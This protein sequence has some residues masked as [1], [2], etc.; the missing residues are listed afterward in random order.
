MSP[1]YVAVPT[2]TGVDDK[3]ASPGASELHARSEPGVAPSYDDDVIHGGWLILK[4]G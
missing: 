3:N 2:L 4:M 1:R